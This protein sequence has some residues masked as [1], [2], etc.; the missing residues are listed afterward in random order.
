MAIGE[1]ESIIM[2]VMKV[3]DIFNGDEYPIKD[4]SPEEKVK[5]KDD[6]WYYEEDDKID[7]DPQYCIEGWDKTVW[8][9]GPFYIIAWNEE[10]HAAMETFMLLEN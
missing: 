2:V 3:V 6:I 1:Q 9:W 4:L 8:K 5:F 10:G 7:G